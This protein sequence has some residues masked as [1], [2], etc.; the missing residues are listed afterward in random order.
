MRWGSTCFAPDMWRLNDP[1]ECWPVRTVFGDALRWVE[2]VESC[3]IGHWTA[4]AL[5]GLTIEC[6]AWW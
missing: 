1:R 6:F 5:R 2:L 3:V 4:A